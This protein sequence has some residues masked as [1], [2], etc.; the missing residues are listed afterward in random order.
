[1]VSS[2]KKK[3]GNGRRRQFKEIF[4]ASELILLF[5]VWI[6]NDYFQ[7][8]IGE[9]LAF[10]LIGSLI[11]ILILRAINRQAAEHAMESN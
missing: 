2:K 11:V 8:T 6:L 10:Y 9:L 5:L 4:C 3:P 1:M 7:A